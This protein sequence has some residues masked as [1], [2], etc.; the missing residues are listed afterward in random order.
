MPEHRILDIV[1]L[2][3]L[4]DWVRDARQRTFEL[5]EDLTEEQ[6]MGPQLFCVN[7]GRWEIGHHAWFQSYWVLR[8]A[9]RQPPVRPDEDALYD[10]ITIAHDDRWVLPLPTRAET[11]EFLREVQQRTIAVLQDSPSDDLVYHALYSTLHEDMHTEAHT[12]TR[13]THHWAR[14]RLGVPFEAPQKAGAIEGDAQIPGGTY[15]LG[16][17]RDEPFVFDNEKWAHPVELQPFA[18]A[19]GAVT[20]QQF[21]A[22]VDDGGYQDQRLWDEEG[23]QWR[24]RVDAEHPVHWQRSSQGWQRYH[25][26]ELRDLEP[27]RP[28]IH[29]NWFEAQAYCR[30]AGRRLPTEAEWEAAA[31]GQATVDGR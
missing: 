30:W 31:I 22:F 3:T 6:L 23:W 1:D 2:P 11:L 20:Q 28:I 13:Q 10:S 29:V 15:T 24:S 8:H 19:R 4:I 16:A 21:A 14:P 17:E 7:P 9:A 5:V 12:Y 18:I 25:F 27:H 26:D